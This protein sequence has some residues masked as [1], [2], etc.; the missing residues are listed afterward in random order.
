MLGKFNYL[1][2]TEKGNKYFF[3]WHIKHFKFFS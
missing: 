1:D 3:Y 2:M